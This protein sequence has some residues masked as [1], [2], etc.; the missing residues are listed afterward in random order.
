MT[1]VAEHLSI[2]PVGIN[3]VVMRYFPEKLEF[4][5]PFY[6]VWITQTVVREIYAVPVQVLIFQGGTV[7]II[8]VTV[9][10]DVYA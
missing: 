10:V 1:A 6:T 3:S 7:L 4:V 2:V 8:P 9:Q 5:N